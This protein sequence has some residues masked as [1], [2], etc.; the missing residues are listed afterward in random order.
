MPQ[1][2]VY[3]GE[4]MASAFLLHDDTNAWTLQFPRAWGMRTGGLRTAIV[5]CSRLKEELL[6]LNTILTVAMHAIGESYC[7][8]TWIRLA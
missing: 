8:G 6:T 4:R 3:R 2:R 7:T 5:R 1:Q